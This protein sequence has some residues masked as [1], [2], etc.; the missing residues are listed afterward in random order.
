[1]TAFKPML[2]PNET[3]AMEDIKFPVMVSNKLDGV[4][5]LFVRGE[6]LS[7][8]MKPFKN[9]LLN[10]KFE[11]LCD[12]SAKRDLV[13][14]GELYLHGMSFQD[15]I[16]YTMKEDTPDNPLEFHCFDVV[17]CGEP[18]ETAISRYDW[19]KQLTFMPG[20][21]VVSQT[22]AYGPDYLREAFTKALDD[23]FEGLILK[24]PYS[25]YKN[26]RVTV[27]S[28]DGYKFKPYRTFDAKITGV[29]QS[30]EVN[31]GSERT[32][33]AF[34]RSVTSKKKGDRHLVEKASAF[35]VEYEG[36]PLKVTLAMTDPEKEATWEVRSECI[37][38]WIEYKAM[39]VGAKDVP[40]H[41]VFVRFREDKE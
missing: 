20:V 35:W 19:C 21:Q 28:G 38:K 17:R 37:G 16:H 9:K 32:L 39:L 25:Y 15:I 22:I 14:D 12:L 41:P 13:I 4:R 36:K 18:P 29:E 31:E 1:M 10:R 8:S 26:G 7:R 5:C 24:G 6:M 3:V 2:F 40:R 23:G 33:D 34:G 27:K 11:F 30:T